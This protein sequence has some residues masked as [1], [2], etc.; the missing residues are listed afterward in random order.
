M[1]KLKKPISVR[2]VHVSV[3]INDKAK[4]QVVDYVTNLVCIYSSFIN[5]ISLPASSTV[6]SDA[7]VC[8]SM[9]KLYFPKNRTR[10]YI[11]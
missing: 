9:E 6:H 10:I 8:L 11:N 3:R 2:V 5:K 4:M 7:P 1:K